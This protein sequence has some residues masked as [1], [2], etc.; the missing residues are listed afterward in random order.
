MTSM[1]E[2]R[3]FI[4]GGV[5]ALAAPLTGEVQEA[6]KVRRVG[7]LLGGDPALMGL[8][9]NNGL[10]RGLRELGYVEGVNLVIDV[11]AAYGKY[12][13]LPSLVEQ[14]VRLRPD[15]VVT[16]T[17]PGTRAAV[18]AAPTTPVVMAAVDDPLGAG[19][20]RSLAR[21]GGNI[22]GMTLLNVD[23]N[24][25]RLQ[26]LTE[27]LPN[28]SRVAVIWNVLTP[29]SEA[30]YNETESAAAALN[31][32][33]VS[34]PVRGPEETARAVA[35]V[36]DQAVQAMIVV[37]DPLTFANRVIREAAAASRVPTMWTFAKE[38]VD[39]G[40]MAYGPDLLDV[41]RTVAIYIDRIFKG[42]KPSD[43]PVEQPTKFEFVI[44]LKT[45]KTLGLTIPPSLLA[46][47]DQIIE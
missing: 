46:R 38:V 15:V 3:T 16:N 21:P 33:I 17:V 24:R 6:R 27:V 10:R 19:L 34:V 32:T 35:T 9:L 39:G 4:V 36:R 45:A 1:M 22:T 13:T 29:Q 5:A 20:I 42:A 18:E 2:R 44:N 28:A 12:E 7:L 14:L 31:M 11:R 8:Q 37:P 43:L 47:A 40:L 25:K 23:F 30:A 26:L 41:Y